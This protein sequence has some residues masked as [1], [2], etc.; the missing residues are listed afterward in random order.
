MAKAKAKT[1]AAKRKSAKGC[2]KD[3]G[4]RMGNV[5][6]PENEVFGSDRINACYHL[7]IKAML[8]KQ[9]LQRFKGEKVAVTPVSP[10]CVDY[11]A[12]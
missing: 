9:L 6:T 4:Y 10:M 11:A 1:K 2:C 8:S 12:S 3:P 5:I 7:K